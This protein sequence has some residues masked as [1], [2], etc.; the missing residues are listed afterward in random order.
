MI[1]KRFYRNGG[2]IMIVNWRIEFKVKGERKKQK[3]ER[4]KQKG[5]SRK[6]KTKG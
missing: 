2:L 1:L 6:A 5:E 4:E 3:A